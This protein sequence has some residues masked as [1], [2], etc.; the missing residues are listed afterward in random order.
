MALNCGIIGLTNTGKTTIFNCMSNTKAEASNYAFSA[1]KSNIGMVEV[2]DPRLDAIDALINSEKVVPAV[3]EIVDL[4]GLAKGSSQGEGVGNKFLADIQQMDALIHVLRC[5]DDDNLPHVEGSIDPV[6]DKDIVDFELQVRD[7]DLVMRKMHRVEKLI[8]A[9]DKEAKKVLEIL[10]VYKS[11][12]E[13]F[14]NARTVE[15]PE[16]D[17][18]HLQELQLLTAKPVIYVCNVDEA[19]ANTGNKYTEAVQTAFEHDQAEILVIAGA[20]EAEIAELENPDDRAEFLSDAGLKEPGVDKLI[21]AA[22]SIL[23]LQ[24]FFTAGP[25]EVK[26]WTIHKG[27]TAPQASGV[28]HSDLE[29][30][31]IRAE[32]M[33]YDDFIQYKSEQGVKDAGKFKVEGKHYIVA[34]G[35]ILHIRFNV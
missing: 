2:P 13:N 16:E 31:F 19:S 20:L 11:H 4:P 3:V 10:H 24:S 25:K 1:T 33:K 17:K 6:R 35:D 26:A 14:G 27:M 34:D 30:G 15:L 9:G 5:F 18:K 29:R 23:D 32:V 28:I 12:L 21:R 8:R 7:L 22:Y